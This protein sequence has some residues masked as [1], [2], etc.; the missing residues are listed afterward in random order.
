MFCPIKYVHIGENSQSTEKKISDEFHLHVH[1]GHPVGHKS[2][3]AASIIH[4]SG[5]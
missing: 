1:R 2:I 5:E 4:V 3:Y